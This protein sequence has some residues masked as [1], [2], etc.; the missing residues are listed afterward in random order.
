MD[1]T[2]AEGQYLKYYWDQNAQWVV[3]VLLLLFALTC[4]RAGLDQDH[5]WVL[6]PPVSCK[7]H[8]LVLQQ[9]TQNR[10]IIS[11]DKPEAQGSDSSQN[12]LSPRKE[13]KLPEYS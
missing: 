5:T 10:K 4:S 11:P 3:F 13:Q 2:Y 12:I 8:L 9:A 7:C 6:T 1:R